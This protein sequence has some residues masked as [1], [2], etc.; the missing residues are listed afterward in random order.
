[1][2]TVKELFC[3][4]LFYILN[5]CL[6]VIIYNCETPRLHFGKPLRK[7]RKGKKNIFCSIVLNSLFIRDWSVND[8]LIVLVFCFKEDPRNIDKMTSLNS[9]NKFQH[10]KKASY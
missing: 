6:L 3:F 8:V 4:S 9:N 2:N 7:K 1:M 5:K 10:I